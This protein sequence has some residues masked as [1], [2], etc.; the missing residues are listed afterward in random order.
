MDV[1]VARGVIELLHNEAAKAA[2]EECCG[3]LLGAPGG[4]PGPEGGERIV[5][6]RPAANVDPAPLRRFEID[7][8]VLLAAHREARGGGPQ[9]LGYYH[10]H[11]VG[12]AEPSVTDRAHSTGDRRIWAIVGGGAGAGEVAFWRDCGKGFDAVAVHLVE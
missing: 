5:A 1:E 9:V 6:I 7:P 8:A 12:K 2:P 3:L 11:P 10:S 4:S